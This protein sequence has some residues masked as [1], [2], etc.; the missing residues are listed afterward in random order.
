[1]L[2]LLMLSS[3]ISATVKGQGLA[4]LSLTSV[5]LGEVGRDVD[6][7]ALRFCEDNGRES[8]SETGS[9][10]STTLTTAL[11]S[12]TF[13]ILSASNPLRDEDAT[14]PVEFC[15]ANA[16]QKAVPNLLSSVWEASE[17]RAAS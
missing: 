10:I 4:H 12:K 2:R 5:I 16:S 11:P 9:S 3:K 15:P 8:G 7:T 17:A 14:G 1:M 6:D 13:R